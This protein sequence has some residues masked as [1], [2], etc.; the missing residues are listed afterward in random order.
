MNKNI[1]R[2]V[3]SNILRLT[4]LLIV[5]PLFF[6]FFY[7]EELIMVI[8]FIIPIIILIISSYLLYP[9]NINIDEEKFHSKDGLL[10]VSLSWL[11]L[12][13]FGSLPFVISGYIPSINDAF[14]ETVSGFTTTGATIL[15]NPEILPNSLLFW[16]SFTHFVGGM[17]VL[18]L[19]LAILPGSKNQY[20]YIIKAEVPG[21]STGKLVA[22][23]SYN[24]RILYTIYISL[25]IIL[26]FLLKLAGMPIF[27][28]IVHAL[29][30]AG[31]GGYSSKALSIAYYNNKHIEYILS[32]GMIVF[33]IN[34][35]IFYLLVLGNVKQALKSEEMKWYFYIILFSTLL[36]S[37]NIY[38]Q[39]NS[40]EE[41]LR[42]AFFTVSSI[43]STTG[44][45]TADYNSWPLLSHIIILL[46]M[47]FGGCAGS[48]AGGFKISRVVV[49]AKEFFKQFKKIVHPNIVKVHKLDGKT[50]EEETISNITSYLIIYIGMFM[51]FLII[52]SFS[53][54]DFLTSF[55][56]LAST[57]NNVG[58]GLGYVGPSF[59][60]SFINPFTKFILSLSMLF[61]RLEILPM[62][63]LFSPT[64]Y[65][66]LK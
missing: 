35:N 38:N 57:F 13:F 26:I 21:P 45:S 59:N 10:I 9:K 19:V 50:L 2:Y 34:F 36:I 55:S 48:T 4:A 49:L 16:R 25:T 64:I 60:Y 18:V 30:T 20:M 24:S 47:F 6:S 62:L 52:I 54:P 63:I 12:S 39:Y 7:R 37:V 32:F 29:G 42:N 14:F 31:T 33:G 51:I 27:D 8:S 44:Y 40:L 66:K 15:N 56:A 58:P 43:I 1:I 11:L 65:K 28:S 5:F 22:K 17:G 53:M 46:L 41:T 61:G 3:I 23:M